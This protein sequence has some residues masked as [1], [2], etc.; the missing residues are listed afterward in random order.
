LVEIAVGQ[1]TACYTIGAVICRA[2][3]ENNRMTL[4]RP[5]DI[6]RPAHREMFSFVVQHMQLRRVEI[7]AGGAI[8]DNRVT[9][10]K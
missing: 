10:S 2:G 1:V 6:Q 8:A 4:R 7:A 5:R 3:L 9:G